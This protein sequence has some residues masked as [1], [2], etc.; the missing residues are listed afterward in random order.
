MGDITNL[1]VWGTVEAGAAVI[2][3][4]LPTLRPLFQGKS[5]ES[6]MGSIRSKLSLKSIDRSPGSQRRE[7]DK[8]GLTVSNGLELEDLKSVG[9]KS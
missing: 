7:S 8:E 5:P 3:A 2:A 4:C 1:V 9:S 6:L